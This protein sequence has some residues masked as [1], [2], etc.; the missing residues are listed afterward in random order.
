MERERLLERLR[1]RLETLERLEPRA[2]GDLLRASIIL[3]AAERDVED[4][5]ARARRYELFGPLKDVAACESALYA[6]YASI[7]L[8]GGGEGVVGRARKDLE[9]AVKALREILARL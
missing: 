3:Q 4:Y 5:A 1:V 2:P 9:E 8:N 7:A 6:T